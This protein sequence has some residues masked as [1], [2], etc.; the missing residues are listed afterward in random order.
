MGDRT[1]ARLEVLAIGEG[2]EQAF[3]DVINEYGLSPDSEMSFPTHGVTKVEPG[4]DYGDY[5]FSCGE[6]ATLASTLLEKAP[7]STWS[8]TEDP[9]YEFLGDYYCN[10]PA[11]GFYSAPCNGEGVPVFTPDQVLNMTKLSELD[12]IKELGLPWL[13]EFA[14]LRK[15]LT[16]ETG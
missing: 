6:G 1:A 7:N 3:L 13:G 14:R 12:L 11:I 4:T 10:I 2:E 5:E 9:A 15:L 8:F 16:E